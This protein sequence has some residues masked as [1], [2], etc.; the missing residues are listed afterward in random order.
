MVL[1]RCPAFACPGYF[2]SWLSVTVSE[3]AVFLGR[4]HM[5]TTNAANT[6]KHATATKPATKMPVF[7]KVP[8]ELEPDPPLVE[9]EHDVESLY[10]HAL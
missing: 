1:L 6:I 4:R 3:T 10:V 9:V 7:A 8:P 5:R 2:S